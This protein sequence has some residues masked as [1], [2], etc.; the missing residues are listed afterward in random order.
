M[1]FEQWAPLGWQ[2][3]IR[4]IEKSSWMQKKIIVDQDV[5]QNSESPNKNG[6]SSFGQESPASF[7][8]ALQEL[9]NRILST[10]EDM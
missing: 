7:I 4:V 5:V 10:S 6:C 9:G 2:W 3:L 1:L 8:S